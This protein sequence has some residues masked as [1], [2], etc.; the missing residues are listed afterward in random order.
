VHRLWRQVLR[1]PRKRPRKCNAT[2]RACPNAP[3]GANQVCSRDFVHW[4]ANGRQLKCLPGSCPSAATL[5]SDNGPEFVSRPLL[6]WPA[7]FAAKPE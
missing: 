6:K 3:T 2:G 5:R 7:A 4:C 1:V